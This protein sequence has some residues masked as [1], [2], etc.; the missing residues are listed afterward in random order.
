MSTCKL[1]KISII[2][3]NCYYSLCLISTYLKPTGSLSSPVSAAS[4]SLSIT[5]GQIENTP[6]KLL[7][8]AALM[9]HRSNVFE[10]K[11]ATEYYTG[12]ALLFFPV[13]V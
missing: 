9:Q 10:N 8:M 6:C 5:K 1:I 2:Y 11:K 7:L 3:N 4:P 13:R 12:G